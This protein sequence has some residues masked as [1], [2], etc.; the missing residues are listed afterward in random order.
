MAKKVTLNGKK[1]VVD[2]SRKNVAAAVEALLNACMERRFEVGSLLEHDNGD[3]TF[4][5]YLIARIIQPNG[6]HRAYLINTETGVARNSR[7]VVLV[8]GAKDE[9]PG[10]ITELPEETDKFI[11]PENEDEYLDC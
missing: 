1:I 6:T 5:D 9:Y 3:G 4:T 7:K 2:M 10:Y 11:D 8:Q